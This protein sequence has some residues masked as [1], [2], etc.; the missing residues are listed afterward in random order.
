MAMP[1]ANQ[2]KIIS[3]IILGLRFAHGIRLVP[4]TMSVTRHKSDAGNSA[5]QSH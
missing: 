4:D 3:V 1:A 2:V 5:A